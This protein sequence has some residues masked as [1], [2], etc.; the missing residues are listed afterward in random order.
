MAKRPIFMR[1]V[2][3]AAELKSN[4]RLSCIS[5][6]RIT[7]GFRGAAN[8][9]Y[10]GEAGLGDGRGA[11]ARV[12]AVGRFASARRARVCAGG[13]AIRSTCARRRA[14]RAW[15]VVPTSRGGAARETR[16][17]PT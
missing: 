6:M 5:T 7:H 16:H 9:P 11:D 3:L 1:D 17:G 15:T 13:A 14:D 12:H 10:G 8:L 4:K 2:K